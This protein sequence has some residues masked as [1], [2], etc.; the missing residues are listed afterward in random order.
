MKRKA[1]SWAPT[2]L[3][4]EAAKNVFL[5]SR[6]TL[7]LVVVI[8]L[9][10]ACS[11][12]QRS[13]LSSFTLTQAER[14]SDGWNV[15]V[16]SSLDAASPT[17]I[18]RGSCERLTQ[19]PRVEGAGVVSLGS[20]VYVPQL[21][22]NVQIARV[23]Q[24][25][26][27]SAYLKDGAIGSAL[28]DGTVPLRVSVLGTPLMLEPLPTLPKGID[29]NSAIVLPLDPDVEWYG[30]CIVNGVVGAPMDE[31]AVTAVAGLVT[32]GGD[33]AA[34]LSVE[35]WID[36]VAIYVGRLGALATFA[37][38]TLGGLL[39]ALSTR[40][41]A[42]ELGVYRLAGASRLSVAS[43]L[44][45]E[46]ALI[47]TCF[48]CVGV[49]SRFFLAPSALTGASWTLGFIGGAGTLLAV[50][51]AGGLPVVRADP[52]RLLAER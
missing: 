30:T 21:A 9:A 50:S 39:L 33:P 8:G 13:E 11:L 38:G 26:I 10:I 12:L 31:V 1:K 45:L 47:A 27:E 20:P 51:W 18:A 14:E 40:W 15:V 34:R 19:D 36:N 52:T 42:S 28:T 23:S 46:A 48:L 32:R 35:P 7:V 3:L 24:S 43:L 37:A 6:L 2:P 25:L 17:E 4:R 5:G 44:G 41:R 22:R 29:F 49:A 16:V